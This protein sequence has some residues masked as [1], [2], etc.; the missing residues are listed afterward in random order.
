MIL[1]AIVPFLP[2]LQNELVYD[3]QLLLVDAPPIEESLTA[4]LFGNDDTGRPASGYYRPLVRLLYGLESSLFGGWP[5]GYHLD[6]LL[7]YAAIALAML[8]VLR[9]VP[10]LA[11]I[12]LPATLLFAV[13]PIHV[14]SVAPVS[15]RTDPLALLCALGA[16]WFALRGQR[17]LPVVLYALSLS[18]KESAVALLPWIAYAPFATRDP[19]RARQAVVL[20]AA[21]VAVSAAFFAVKIFALGIVPPESAFTGEGRL[22][23]RFLT[24][25][26]VLPRY[27]GL[28][29]WPESLSI[30][31]DVALVTSPTD[32]RLWL[33]VGVLFVLLALLRV[34]PAPIRIGVL[35]FLLTL[36]PASN[37]VPITYAFREVPFPFFER[38]LFVPLL[39][40]VIAAA[41]L[42][43]LAAK[44]VRVTTAVAILLALPLGARAWD[45]CHDFR[46]DVILYTEAARHVRDRRF[47]LVHVAYAR[48]RGQ[49]PVAAMKTFDEVLAIDPAY[50]EARLGKATVL[51][52]LAHAYQN[53][54]RLHVDR[55]EE[56]E[57]AAMRA[58]ASRLIASAR[59]LLVPLSD[60]DH[61]TGRA[62]EALGTLAGLEGDAYEA[63][64]LYRRA[65]DTRD[66]SPALAANFRKLALDFME[67]G[68]WLTQQRALKEANHVFE[69][70]VRALCGRVPP[71]DV[72]DP[73]F[74]E[75][76]KILCMRADNLLLLGGRAQAQAAY[77][78]VLER[79]AD[80]YRCH[81][82]L[83]YLAKQSGDRAEALR[84]FALALSIE[85]NAFYALNEMFTMLM[86]DGRRDEAYQYIE[87]LRRFYRDAEVRDVPLPITKPPEI[88]EARDAK[89]VDDP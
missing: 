60:P 8:H 43:H 47:L 74:D 13:H 80:Q 52:T 86:E 19:G 77:L 20:L 83:G 56:N 89:P 44:D 75:V 62:L 7:I 46:S 30:V 88:P 64:R 32:P 67:E 15:G 59:E 71:A 82:G 70:A 31:H 37:V 18:C 5:V 29:V 58:E 57:A 10:A 61:P 35:L 38:Y 28:V 81:E 1:A 24:F 55:H 22:A 79:D 3:D 2:T 69:N 49:D 34:G 12:A 84:R 51:A 41:G 78:D 48:L 45:R 68:R 50:V 65:W 42:V 54:A 85:P 11:V 14:E 76:I 16:I 72:P 39:G 40:V 27:L 17:L 87:R 6:N 23:E 4:D 26:A 73:I 9:A 36:L 63:A 21:G 66:F 33:G 53:E 25:V